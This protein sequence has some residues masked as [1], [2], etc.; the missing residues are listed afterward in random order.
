M[1]ES[2]TKVVHSLIWTT[3]EKNGKTIP[4]ISTRNHNSA[5]ISA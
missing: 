2:S 4:P 3:I 1:S 5:S